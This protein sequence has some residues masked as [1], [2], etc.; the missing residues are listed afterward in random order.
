MFDF[1]RNLKKIPSI[2]NDNLLS[3]KKSNLFTFFQ[4]SRSVLIFAF[5]NHKFVLKYFTSISHL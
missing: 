2:L 3:Y 5:K 1:T 4:L